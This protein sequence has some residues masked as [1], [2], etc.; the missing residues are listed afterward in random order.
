M[1]KSMEMLSRIAFGAASLVLIVLSL[2]LVING[3]VDGGR[4]PDARPGRMP[5]TPCS[6]PSATW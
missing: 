6:P 3:A 5:A 1:T 2:A 4:R